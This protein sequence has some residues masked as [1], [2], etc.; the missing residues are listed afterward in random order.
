MADDLDRALSDAKKRAEGVAKEVM[1][2]ARA[3]GLGRTVEA[4]PCAP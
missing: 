3:G 1:G 4:S 2:A